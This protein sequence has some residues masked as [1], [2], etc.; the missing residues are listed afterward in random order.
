LALI[1]TRVSK[2][3]ALEQWT[4]P[5]FYGEVYGIRKGAALSLRHAYA[6]SNDYVQCI[7]SSAP[8]EA[9]QFLSYGPGNQSVTRSYSREPSVTVTITT[10]PG[11]RRSLSRDVS[12]DSDFSEPKGASST[13]N[14]RRK[15]DSAS[16]LHSS[17]SSNLNS[18]NDDGDDEDG[19]SGSEEVEESKSE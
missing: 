3:W 12:G 8:L 15:S 18:R 2:F 1:R 4:A 6:L 11:W 19:C 5:R 14:L 13:S 17:S 10:G 16:N 9:K 7:C